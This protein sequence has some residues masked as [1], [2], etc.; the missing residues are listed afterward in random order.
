M[1]RFATRRNLL[2]LAAAIA[3]FAVVSAAAFI[4]GNTGIG[5]VA[6]ILAGLAIIAPFVSQAVAN[7]P[8]IRAEF[9]HARRQDAMVVMLTN[10]GS[11]V[12]YVREATLEVESESGDPYTV[13]YDLDEIALYPRQRAN[14]VISQSNMG[15]RFVK[16]ALEKIVLTFRAT[17]VNGNGRPV[18]TIMEVLPE[19]LAPRT[20]SEPMRLEEPSWRDQKGNSWRLP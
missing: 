6:A 7:S 13:R 15:G 4:A 18:T 9:I 2:F 16:M 20:I 10:T 17:V 12:G 1:R 5:F 14:L 11:G 8:R 3:V 19:S